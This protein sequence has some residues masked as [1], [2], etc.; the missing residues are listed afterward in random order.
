MSSLRLFVYG[1]LRRGCANPHAEL[2]RRSGQFVGRGKVRGKLYRVDWYP[3]MTLGG[4]EWVVGDVF[5][6]DPAA[7]EELDRYEGTDEYRRVPATAFMENGEL[8]ECWVYEYIAPVS[9]AKRIES[10]DWMAEA[11]RS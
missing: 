6:V 2:L 7:M 4:G 10:G 5:A 9:E 11:E 3:G 1:T 8:A